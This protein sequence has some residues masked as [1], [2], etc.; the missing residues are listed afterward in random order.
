MSLVGPRAMSADEHKD[1]EQQIDGFEKRL[2]VRPGLTGL[3]KVYNRADDPERNLELDLEYIEHISLWL[4]VKLV[5]LS[6]RNTLLGSWDSRG[7]K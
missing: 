5:L 7:A 1:L 3:S 4:D 2:S 6:I